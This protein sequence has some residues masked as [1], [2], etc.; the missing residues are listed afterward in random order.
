MS[1][2]QEDLAKNIEILAGFVSIPAPEDFYF[3]SESQLYIGN[4]FLKE[5]LKVIHSVLEPWI[6]VTMETN[7]PGF[8]NVTRITF[9]LKSP[10]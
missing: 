10:A 1:Y 3:W 2:T 7:P 9:Q 8:I 6:T 4:D 5:T